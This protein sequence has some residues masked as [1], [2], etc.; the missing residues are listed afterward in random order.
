MNTANR[1]VLAI[2]FL[3]ISGPVIADTETEITRALEYFVEIWNEGDLD[4]LRGYYHP[5]FVLVAE[6]GSIA[7]G[8]R[9][10]D[11]KAIAQTGEDRGV[12]EYSH[13]QVKAL[14]KKHALA[15]GELHLK[16][17]DGSALNS[18]FTTVYLKTP[19]GWKAI[20]THN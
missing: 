7:L 16:F 2:T 18:W 8:Q 17:K 19:F 1:I 9:I 4:E 10:D 20:L 5:D 15:Y 11:L 12:L 13:I 6:R 14:E 3:L